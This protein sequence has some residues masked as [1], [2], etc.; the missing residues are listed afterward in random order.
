MAKAKAEAK[1]E[2]DR[3]QLM[4]IRNIR[5]ASY[6]LDWEMREY[7]QLYNIECKAFGGYEE[8]TICDK[9]NDRIANECAMISDAAIELCEAGENGMCSQCEADY[10]ALFNVC[11][12]SSAGPEDRKPVDRNK[13]IKYLMPDVTLKVKIK[14]MISETNADSNIAPASRKKRAIKLGDKKE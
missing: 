3:Q 4:E 6:L 12:R 5:I 14:T 8:N 1:K 10:P 2:I 13:E 9:C 11:D 7:Q